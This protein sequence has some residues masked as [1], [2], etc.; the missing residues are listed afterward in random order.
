MRIS[1][2]R[3]WTA[4]V[5]ALS[6]VTAFYLMQMIIGTYPWQLA[7][8]ILLAN[9]VCLG[10]V[11]FILCAL[12]NHIAAAAILLHIFAWIWGT[13]NAFIIRFRGTPILPWDFTAL[14]TAL[15]V[16]GRYRFVPTAAMIAGAAAVVLLSVVI[17]KKCAGGQW[18]LTRANLRFRLP[19]MILGAACL[20]LTMSETFLTE[21]GVEADVWDQAQ[22]C[23]TTGA[24]ASF[25]LNTKFM[26]VDV[27]ED[28]SDERVEEIMA[29][30]AP[31]PPV[32]L[33]EDIHRPNIIAVMNES[34]ADFEDFGN[35]R[36]S[37]SVT[38]YVRSLD[39]IYG[40]AYTSVFGAGTSASEFEFL[41][42]N[43]MAFL[44]SG[45]IPYQQYV[46]HDTESLASILRD[47][48]YQC[49]AMH[50]GERNSWQRSSAYP[51][52]GFESFTCVEDMHVPLTDKHGYVGDDASFAEIIYQ[53][54]HRDPTKPFFMF[55]VTIQNHG[56]YT[57][58][59]YETQVYLTDEKGVYPQAEQY[60]TLVNQSDEAFRILTDYFSVCGEP[61]IILMFGDH[62]PSLE[63]EFLDKAY[64]VTQS[65]MTMAQYLGKFK[66]PFVFWANYELPEAEIPDTSLNFLGQ[67]LLEFAGIDTTAFGD[68]LCQ[69]REA[70][71]ALTF[72]GYWDSRGNAYSHLETTEFDP[73]IDAYQVLQY[74]N[75]FG[76]PE[77]IE[78]GGSFH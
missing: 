3:V 4:A 22:S 76:D 17:H 75:L 71:P 43:S 21:C 34:W 56:S 28:Y 67:Y 12:T 24:V 16:A 7:P 5:F 30:V 25:I 10:A 51:L 61:T 2:Q 48:G 11:Y 37:E 19:A 42:G 46:L 13:A 35:L 50:P 68:F 40:H 58:E 72:A 74:E 45:S 70:L 18:R 55:N 1:K 23:R 44:P 14:D 62:Q 78:A 63:T 64:G 15:D 49:V 6:P 9:Y 20:F 52:L 57:D 38:D 54:E 53:Y 32:R 8:K 39:G 41:T 27:P 77:I 47:E 66:V 73:Q 60:L 36:L 33:S 69:M 65:E 29:S 31:R 26:K 59:N